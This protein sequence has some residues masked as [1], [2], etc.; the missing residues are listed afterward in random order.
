MITKDM[1]VSKML[2]DYPETLKVM[3][4]SSNLFKRLKN[5]FLRKSLAGRVNVEQAASVAG[6]N[7][8]GLVLKLNEAIGCAN[9]YGK[10]I[11]DGK[12]KTDTEKKIVVTI[13][14]KIGEMINK[15]RKITLDVRQDIKSGSD[16]LKKIM[17]VQKRLAKDE[18]LLLINS[19]EPI[20]LYTVMSRKGFNHLTEKKDGIFYVYFYR[21]EKPAVSEPELISKDKIYIDIESAEKIIEIDVRELEPPEPM[22]K[23][24]EALSVL[25]G[26]SVLLVH[27][28]REP[29]MLYPKLE[30][31]GF[32]A[33]CEKISD[34]YF[35][36]FIAKGKSRD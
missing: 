31:R 23:V 14:D 34:N 17:G 35:K 7:P 26:N 1:K 36:I 27:H 13:D 9:E 6:L 10:Q 25:K 24:L 4:A 2:D 3:L 22:I 5:R 30:E 12:I 29:V 21:D 28:H 32:G 11:A 33:V 8:D 18:V 16:P 20:P 15:S 19:F